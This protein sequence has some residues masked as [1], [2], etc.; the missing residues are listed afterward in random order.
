MC[1]LPTMHEYN[2]FVHDIMHTF[3]N[4]TKELLRIMIQSGIQDGFSLAPDVVERFDK[5]IWYWRKDVCKQISDPPPPLSKYARWKA[6]ECKTFALSFML[7]LFHG[8]MD[9]IYL[10][11]LSKFATIVDISSRPILTKS[12]IIELRYTCIDF[13]EH[14]EREY[15][16]YDR[17]RANLCKSI[18]HVLLHLADC[19]EYMGPLCNVSQ[20]WMERYVGWIGDRL[21]SRLRPAESMIKSHL[22]YESYKMAFCKPV[23]NK[24]SQFESVNGS[25][26]FVLLGPSK[27]SNLNITHIG[28]NRKML[29]RMYLRR[30]YRTITNAK[31]GNVVDC[32]TEVKMYSRVQFVI[33]SD[34]ISAGVFHKIDC[35]QLR[36]AEGRADY[37][38]AVEMDHT[39]NSC[40]VYYGRLLELMEFY[41]P[42]GILNVFEQHGSYHR[43]GI[44][45]WGKRLRVGAQGQIYKVGTTSQVFTAATIEDIAG[46]T[47]L[48]SVIQHS[49]PWTSREGT[50]TRS[51]FVDEYARIDHLLTNQ[52]SYDGYNRKLADLNT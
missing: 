25:G 13:F 30:K 19:T 50:Q 28:V 8:F 7:I 29:F 16:K 1:C 40:D 18:F 27:L 11:G 26:G 41:I 52:K 20:F 2:S 51:Y 23:H 3:M 17:S 39:E 32:I 6:A 37:Y 4:I 33:G 38:V 10:D 34:V 31:I 22:Y 45:D 43:V 36:K 21:N 14:Y 5:E 9:D 42:S 49:V 46:I 44:F 35:D 24:I 12:D 15:F 48:I 47:R